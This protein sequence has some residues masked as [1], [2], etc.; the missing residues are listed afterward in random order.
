MAQI[1]AKG[2]NYNHKNEI[3]WYLA[4]S[5]SYGQLDRY[6]FGALVFEYIIAVTSV[7]IVQEPLTRDKYAANS[8]ANTFSPIPIMA[9]QKPSD[10]MPERQDQWSWMLLVGSYNTAYQSSDPIYP[11]TR[12]MFWIISN[13]FYCIQVMQKLISYS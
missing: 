4:P 5:L 8:K 13:T 12:C 11:H 3:G 7:F 9:M 6:D 10:D 2:L 1:K